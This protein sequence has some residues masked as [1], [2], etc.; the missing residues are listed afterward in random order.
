[1]PTAD[2]PVLSVVVRAHGDRAWLLHDTLLALAAQTDDDLE[3][4]LLADADRDSGGAAEELVGA[5]AKGFRERVRRIGAPAQG[6][7]RLVDVAA[8][9]A[10]GAYLAVLSEGEVPLGH[11][12]A[13]LRR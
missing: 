2:L 3:V 1:M 10:Q 4:L 9:A 12:A 13:E 7:D 6:G 5:F 8:A 11:W